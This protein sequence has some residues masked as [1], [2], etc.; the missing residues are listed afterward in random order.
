MVTILAEPNLTTVSGET[1]SFL[2]GGEV[3]FGTT[4]AN[5]NATIVFKPFGISLSFTPTLLDRDRISINVRPEVSQVGGPAGSIGGISV[6]GLTTRRAE[7]TVELGDGQSLVLAGLLQRN[8][9]ETISKVPGL[10]DIPILGALFRSENFINE[11]TE[12]MII[13]TPYIVRP[14]SERIAMPTDGFQPPNDYER[15][16]W[17]GMYRQ[18]D[19]GAPDRVATS[20]G[21]Q[22]VGS[23]GF[24]VE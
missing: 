11:E 12:L 3:P 19:G 7:T 24:K 13:V 20:G 18:S 17:G 8:I 5:G 14:T 1:A 16:L 9:N 23:I 10:G 15:I 22:L 4:D 21:K 6:R 2:A